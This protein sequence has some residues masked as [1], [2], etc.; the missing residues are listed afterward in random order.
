MLKLQ[1]QNIGLATITLKDPQGYSDFVMEIASGV[2]KTKDITAD[3]L[4]RLETQLQNFETPV[5]NEAGTTLLIGMRWAVLSASTD[6]RAIPE[7][8][9]GL[10]T[11]N[12]LRLSSYDPAAGAT[13]A[14]A[15]G[16]GLLG[17]QTKATLQT[18]VGTARLDLEAVQ[19]GTAG[20]DTT[21]EIVTPTS[22]LLITVVGTKITVRP[23]LGGST[24]AAIA[25]ALNAD[26][27]AKYLIQA[28][29]GVAGTI[30]AA[31]AET[32]LSGG[33]GSG[34][35]LTLGGTACLF[36][37]VLNTQLTFDIPT[38]IS[39]T[40]RAL[41]LVY[42]CG[43]HVTTL[44]LMALG[45]TA[46]GIPVGEK[47]VA[48]GVATLDA[49]AK[50]PSAQIPA[51]ALP[52][53]HVVADAA[54]RV[55]LT[56]QEGDE[57]IQLD[58]GSH[59]IYDGAAWHLRQQTMTTGLPELD[60]L[61]IAG[62]A[63]VLAAG[64]PIKLVGRNLLQGQTF[65]SL[66]LTEGAASL[67]IVALKPGASAI[68]VE[69]TVGL[70]GLVVSYNAGLK[71]LTIELAA[72]GSTDDDVAT[73]INANASACKGILR[74][75]SAAGGSFT[76]A[77]SAAP[78]TGGT[79]AYANNSVMVGGLEALPINEIGTTTTAKWTNTTI[80]CETQAVGGVAD[81]VTLSISSNLH[82]SPA[83]S[84]VLA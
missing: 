79:G 14:V 56:V 11:L 21:F 67:D 17:G 39:A 55:A 12:E 7:G 71:A 49:G 27:A 2:T 75:T 41:P 1:V 77:Q 24:V 15:T 58:D 62:G 51:V 42:R 61:N 4:Q 64:G 22:T 63:A 84:A 31:V 66:T 9:S 81:I 68:T 45:A 6:I 50:I 5:Y 76:L 8:P 3:V 80:D 72:A 48:N 37:E 36:T 47:G 10:P 19:P 59:W 74:A 46:V 40:G 38:G 20:N 13:D 43:P 78:L 83:L 53:V 30:N 29:E 32:A 25:A 35:Q 57:A 70:G 44:S 65:D 18:L 54:A 23:A 73:A 52:S 69:M 34:L 28:T 60:R 16:T 33:L 82:R 26:A